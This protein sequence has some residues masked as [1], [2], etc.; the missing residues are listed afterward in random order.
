MRK[1]ISLIAIICS[2]IGITEWRQ[3]NHNILKVKRLL[4]GIQKLKRST[5]KDGAKKIQRDKFIVREH[6]NYIDVCQSFVLK[7]KETIRILRELRILSLSQD[8]RLN[9]V[10]EYIR[11]AERQIDQIRRRVIFD[12][13]ISQSLNRIPSGLARVKPAYR[14]S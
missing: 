3:S 6:Q 8:L 10:E 11:H 5:S 12:E 14:K 13:K 4:R 1:M 2:E 9:A 7:A